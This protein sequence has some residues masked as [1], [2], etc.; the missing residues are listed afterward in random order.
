MEE[1]IIKVN[2]KKIPLSAY[3]KKIITNTIITMLK[4]LRDV[5]E[6]KT[7]EIIIKS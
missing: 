2:G 4:T 3:P 1:T 6:L 7:V 5:D